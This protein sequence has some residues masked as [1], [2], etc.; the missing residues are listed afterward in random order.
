MMRAVFLDR[1]GVLNRVT[2]IQ[3]TP[4]P[5]ENLNE[6]EVIPGAAKACADLKKAGFLL[7]VVSNQP[8][9]ARG[10]QQRAVVEAINRALL[11][12]VLLDDVKVCFHDDGDQCS[13][14]KPLPGMLMQAADEWHIDLSA[15]FMVGDRWKDIETGRK[16]G[17]R[18]VLIDCH[19]EERVPNEPDHRA[20]SLVEAAEW[21]LLQVNPLSD[22]EGP[23][24]NF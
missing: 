1:D 2:V 17:C 5:P 18:T 15:S 14:R 12:E 21:I 8:D 10:T 24:E 7:I 4:H 22:T 9:V 3:G 19:Y 11:A 13:C 16:A 6:F 20:N 23:H